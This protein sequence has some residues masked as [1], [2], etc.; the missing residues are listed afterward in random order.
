MKRTTS[1]SSGLNNSDPPPSVAFFREGAPVRAGETIVALG[2]PLSGLLSSDANVSVGN[3][4]ALAGLRDDSRYLQISAPVQPGNSGGPLLDAS[5]H[6]AGIVTAKLDA[7][8][9]ARFT[10]DIPQNINFALKAEVARTFLDSK[11][12]AY[13]TARSDR[14]LSPADVGDIGRPFTVHIACERLGS[15]A[16]A[17]P[18]MANPPP[19]ADIQATRQQISWCQMA[20]IMK[21]ADLIIKGCTAVIRSDRSALAFHNRGVAYGLKGDYDRAI[22]DFDDAIAL[23]SNLT[24]AFANRGHAYAAKK[25]YDRAIADYNRAVQ[26]NSLCAGCFYNRG[27]VFRLKRDYELA[28]QDFITA[29]RSADGSTE[30][31]AANQ[32]GFMW[33]WG[34]GVAQDYGEAMRWFRLAAERGN[35]VAMNNIGEL[36][37]KG[38]GVSKDCES[39]RR[40]A[41]NAAKA[42]LEVAKQHLRSG[43]DGQCHW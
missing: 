26:L 23:D 2:Y 5:G 32:I 16:A 8:R 42:G 10:G 29:S 39:A 7:M 37:A 38:Q 41:D 28:M 31:L 40:W 11:G 24:G 34:E 6:L 20:L 27:L 17:K 22:T 12:I 4:S 30:S 14:Q 21:N 35:A 15:Q 13:Q 1:R 19:K 33:A 9:L 36:Y 25:D 43:F 3:V 18:A